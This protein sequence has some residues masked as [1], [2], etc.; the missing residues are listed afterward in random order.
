LHELQQASHVLLA[1]VL[2]FEQLL[3][4]SELRV[5]GRVRINRSSWAQLQQASSFVGFACWV[6][7]QLRVFPSTSVKLGA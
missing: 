3:A 7:A 4:V 6:A 1:K 2:P 5:E